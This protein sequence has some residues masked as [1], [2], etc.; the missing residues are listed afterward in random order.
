MVTILIRKCKFSLFSKKSVQRLKVQ[1]CA[2]VLSLVLA[3]NKSQHDIFEPYRPAHCYTFSHFGLEAHPQLQKVKHFIKD[4]QLKPASRLNF[5]FFKKS[6]QNEKKCSNA[7]AY[8]IRKYHA[9]TY[10][11]SKAVPE[12]LRIATLLISGHFF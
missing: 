10:Y 9:K 6:G 3:S 2:D 12:R 4:L 7:Q 11:K 8:T 1:Q 5:T